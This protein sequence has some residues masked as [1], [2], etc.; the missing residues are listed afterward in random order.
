[1]GNL[2]ILIRVGV[3]LLDF[4]HIFATDVRVVIIPTHA[5]KT[6]LTKAKLSAVIST[7]RSH[8]C[9]THGKAKLRFWRAWMETLPSLVQPANIH[10]VPAS[11][12]YVA[13]FVHK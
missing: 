6:N 13:P 8:A 1:M 9:Q 7:W 2:V 5:V 4:N 12:Y 3:I 11:F 10:F